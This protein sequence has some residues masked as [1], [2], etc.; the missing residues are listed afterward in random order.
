MPTVVIDPVTRIE[1]HL[2]VEMDVEN[3]SVRSAKNTAALYRG[4]ENIVLHRDPRDCP[5]ILSAVCGVCHSDHHIAGVRTL[6]NAAGI[7]QYVNSYANEKT[8]LPP[9]AVLSRNIIGA[10]DWTYSHAAHILALAGPDYHLYGL[11]EALSQSL[12]VNSYADLMR[13]V[14]IPAQAYANQI[15]TLW[16]GKAPHSR[17]SVPGGN[18]V[19]PTP[20][21][22][23]QT[24]A[25]ISNFRTIL[26][27]AAPVIWNYFTSNAV[28]LAALGPG[29]GGFVSMGN[30]PDPTTS[31]GT[32]SMPLFV[33]RGAIF[34]SGTAPVPFDPALI[35]E[36][37]SHSW[38]NQPSP[39][40][41]IGE[42]TPV[43]DM[44]NAQA[45]SWAKSPRFNG[46]VCES[47][48]LAREYVSGV[49]PALGKVINSIVSSVPGLPLNP[50]GSVFDRMVAR[51]L[52]LVILN[53]SNNTTKN[54]QVL[55]Q[56]LN[57][58]LVDVLDALGV[59]QQGLM[60]HWLDAMDVGAPAYVSSYQNPDQ[61]EGIGLWEAPRG[62]LFHWVRIKDQK[63]DDYQVIAPTTWNVS[64]SGPL[65]GALVGTP[66]GSA[67]TDDDLRQA[68]YVIRSFDLCLACTVHVVDARGN[69]RYLKMG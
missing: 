48:P 37:T 19:R 49:Y 35:T 58:S 11:L 15:I 5:P 26:D 43:P 17:S 57:L 53:G 56:D 7:T 9:N 4:F 14:V 40:A 28:Q 12:V 52:E 13:V 50:K 45:Y 25:R 34:P 32:D 39:E 55:G 20:E 61:A 41:V 6:E 42:Q 36:D 21:V 60:Q 18:P 68:A 54:L 10:A 30:F 47:G 69:D 62:S 38:Y 29:S 65:E 22:I 64:P 23:A 24:S 59:P 46:Q 63:V 27:I 2:R 1:G 33:K 16:G 31:G 3:G 8:S 51:A 44:T 66:I 67:G